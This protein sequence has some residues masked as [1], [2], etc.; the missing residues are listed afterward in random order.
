MYLSNQDFIWWALIFFMVGG[1]IEVSFITPNLKI[2]QWQHL[3]G[4][5]VKLPK[6]LQNESSPLLWCGQDNQDNKLFL[7]SR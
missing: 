1:M 5:C 3:S 2:S 6:Q 7:C 4:D